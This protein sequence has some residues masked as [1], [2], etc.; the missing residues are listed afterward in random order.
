M[1]IL[2]SFMG[3]GILVGSGLGRTTAELSWR[4]LEGCLAIMKVFCWAWIGW[5]G[6]FLHILCFVNGLDFAGEVF[7]AFTIVHCWVRFC[8]G[9]FPSIY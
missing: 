8:W 4:A 6:F 7:I 5:R 3:R 2:E 1:E 9:G